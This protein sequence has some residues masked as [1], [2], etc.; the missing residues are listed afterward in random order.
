MKTQVIYKYKERI[1]PKNMDH[2]QRSQEFYN[3][4]YQIKKLISS[5]TVQDP[6]ILMVHLKK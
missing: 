3:S 5:E 4:N 6:K 2:A 1:L